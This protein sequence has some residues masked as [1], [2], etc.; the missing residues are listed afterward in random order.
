MYIY[1]NFIIS[2]E[3]HPKLR[4]SVAKADGIEKSGE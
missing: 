1:K 2:V 4:E 3:N